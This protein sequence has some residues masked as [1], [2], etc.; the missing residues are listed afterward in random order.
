MWIWRTPLSSPAHALA[1][2]PL[3]RRPF[4]RRHTLALRPLVR[5]PFARRHYYWPAGRSPAGVGPAG[6]QYRPQAFGPQACLA[7]RLWVMFCSLNYWPDGEWSCFYWW[8]WITPGP[9]SSCRRGTRR[10]PSSPGAGLNG[11]GIS[12]AQWLRAVVGMKHDNDST[13]GNFRIN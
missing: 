10:G 4:A 7:P 9:A 13:N 8:F 6:L 11:K 2:R 1:L 12:I 3:V 5:R